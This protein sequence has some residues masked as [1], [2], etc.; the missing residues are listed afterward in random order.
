VETRVSL[1][2][3]G[4]ALSGAD[5]RFT[6]HLARAEETDRNRLA[7][8]RAVRA[9]HF[10]A[11]LRDGIAYDGAFREDQGFITHARLEITRVDRDNGTVTAAIRSLARARVFRDFAGTCDPAGGSVALVATGRGSFGEDGSFDVPFLTSASASTVHLELTGNSITGRIEGDP[12]WIMEFPAGS[13][14]SAPTEG[15]GPDAPPANGS[16]FPTFPKE[17]GAYLLTRAGWS[18][19]PKN[20][21][22]V[23]VEKLSA[24][25]D[26]DIAVPSNIAGAV[27][28]GLS[29]GINAI[30]HKKEKEKV[31]YLVFDGKAPRPE[32]SGPAMIILY[33]G[34]KLSD[35]GRLELAPTDLGKDGNRRIELP[36]G[37]A[38]PAV[39]A[40]ASPEAKARA[41]PAEIHLGE[42]RLAAFVRSGGPGYTLYTSTSTLVPGPY[43]FNADAPYELTED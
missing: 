29:A 40:D 15:F 38:P 17:A 41:E 43:V 27:T 5:A 25:S 18:A 23:V 3:A 16:V 28:A 34:P 6:Y 35:K 1:S 4:G 39:P 36:E 2:A 7:A 21:G 22:H 42:Q 9:R 11:V 30:T 26:S 13:F 8:G 33:V 24:K 32:S 20:N 37:T 31:T 14:L 10:M 12:H 19:L